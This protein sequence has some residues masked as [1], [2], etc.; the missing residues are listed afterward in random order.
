MTSISPDDECLV[1]GTTRENHGDLNH[2]FSTDGQLVPKKSG[3][4]PR[5]TPPMPRT[6]EGAALQKDPTN[7]LLLRLIERLV[8]KDL[9]QGQDLL[10]MFGATDAPYRRDTAQAAPT[11]RDPASTEGSSGSDPQ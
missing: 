1:C 11:Y 7:N 2:E 10:Y 5:Q 6:A 8:A 9:L 4:A 3:A